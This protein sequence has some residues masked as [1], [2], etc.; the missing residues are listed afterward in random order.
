MT[1]HADPAT[2][3]RRRRRGRRALN[4]RR[5]AILEAV[6]SEYIGTAEPVGSVPR[7]QRTGGA[8]VLRHRALG[9]GGARAGG[10]SRPAPHE[11]RPHPDRQGLPLLRRPPD[12]ARACSAPSQR[13]QVTQFF[14][15]VHGEMETV[16]ERA[17]G[18]ALRADLLRRRRRRS[19]ARDRHHPLGPAGRPLAAPRAARRRALRR[20]RR[21]ADHRP[22]RRGLRGDAGPRRRLARLAP[23]RADAVG[24]LDRAGQRI[25]RSSTAWSPPRT[26][27]STPWGEPWTPTR[28]SSAARPAW[29]SPST[30]SR[31]CA[32]CWPSSS[33]SWSW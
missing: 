25:R 16:L 2:D 1:T 14:D 31:P 15:Q 17:I 28:C 30:P 26:A 7:G 22:R 8:G 32:R 18:P 19:L 24:T 4:A 20:R 12:R 5:A 29:P 13:R 23:G 6:V 27:P 3:R 21:E 33:S 11:R 10:L 9:D